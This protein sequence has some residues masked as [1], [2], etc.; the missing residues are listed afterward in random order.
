MQ[1]PGP[2]HATGVGLSFGSTRRCKGS[3]CMLK[4]RYRLLKGKADACAAVH[5]ILAGVNALGS[6][7]AVRHVPGPHCHRRVRCAGRPQGI[8]SV[9]A[10]GVRGG[11]WQQG[12]GCWDAAGAATAC[13]SRRPEDFERRGLSA[14]FECA[15]RVV[16]LAAPAAAALAAT[17]RGIQS[18]F[19][20]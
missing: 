1:S 4:G 16:V 11:Y 13:S 6:S 8:I 2:T 20:F 19:I 3:S 10:W 9:P 17:V 5:C 7:C 12:C 14:H 15:R 18:L